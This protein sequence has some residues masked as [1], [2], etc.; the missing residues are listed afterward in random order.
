M[1]SILGAS[2]FGNQFKAIS[3]LEILK[4]YGKPMRPHQNKLFLDLRKSRLKVTSFR[5]ILSSTPL[6]L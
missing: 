3:S 6:F 2:W 4:V 5:E 1:C